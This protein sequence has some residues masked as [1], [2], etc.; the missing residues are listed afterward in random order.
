MKKFY[1]FLNGLWNFDYEIEANTKEEAINQAIYDM[2]RE[3]GSID[4]DHIDQ[5]VVEEKES[6]CI[7]SPDAEDMKISSEFFPKI[8]DAKYEEEK[9]Q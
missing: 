5:Y 6:E 7:S 8:M 1:V 2:D 4:I 9:A 3:S